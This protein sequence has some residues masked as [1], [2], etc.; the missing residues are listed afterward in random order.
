[1]VKEA[2]QK[3]IAQLK[4]AGVP[5]ARLD[6][7]YLV[8]E[9]AGIPRLQ[10]L[11]KADLSLKADSEQ[12]LQRW[13]TERL[14]RRP[15]AYV[16]GEQP[17]MDLKLRVTPAVLIPRPETELLVEEAYRLLD[18]RQKAVVADV[19]TGSG[20]IALSLAGHPNVKETHAIDISEAALDLAKENAL[21]NHI[22][23]EIH[24]HLGDLLIPLL[25]RPGSVDLIAANLPYIKLEE[26]PQLAPEVRWEPGLALNGGC[27]GLAY[28][29]Q[30]IEQ[31]KIVL[32]PGGQLLL[33]IG[34]EQGAD[35]LKL[36]E[37]DIWMSRQLKHDLAGHPRIVRAQKGI[38]VGSVNH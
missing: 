10:L 2:L 38:P 22:R 13:T 24:W 8:A 29:A 33:E 5:E 15:L 31:A 3:T 12:Q 37:D 35:V 34:A 27:D 14:Q 16:L 1:M 4:Q 36:L 19:G 32:C 11:L 26:L 6:A 20:N 30:L 9:A 23:K 7:E 25:Q 18:S 17:F 21:R 28:I